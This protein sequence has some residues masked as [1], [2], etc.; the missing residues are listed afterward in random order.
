MT[1]LI[2]K[3]EIV[4]RLVENRPDRL[5]ISES[6]N[7]IILQQTTERRIMISQFF[8]LLAT[9]NCAMGF[10]P[11]KPPNV[12]KPVVPLVKAYLAL[13]QI[14]KGLQE[15][16]IST[17]IVLGVAESLTF[18]VVN[19][20]FHDHGHYFAGTVGDP[21]FWALRSFFSDLIS[22]ATQPLIPTKSPLW[23]D[24]PEE[25]ESDPTCIKNWNVNDEDKWL[26]SKDKSFRASGREEKFI[27]KQRDICIAKKRRK[28]FSSITRFVVI[29]LII[30]SMAHTLSSVSTYELIDEILKI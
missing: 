15:R 30:H 2:L 26:E 3:T 20:I 28:V 4:H 11:I 7:R 25:L 14:A 27:C 5:H 23:Q 29:P 6:K 10:L 21:V 8:T 12:G 9:F 22:K 17:D 16:S 19:R 1:S 24:N 13:E 18:E